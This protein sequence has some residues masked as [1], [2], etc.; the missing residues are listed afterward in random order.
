M[1]NCT[2]LFVID[3]SIVGTRDLNIATT[4]KYQLDELL[5]IRFLTKIYHIDEQGQ[6]Q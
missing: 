2:A 5:I 1:E 6:I 4:N 3:N